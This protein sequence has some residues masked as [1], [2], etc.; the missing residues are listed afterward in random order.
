MKRGRLLL[1]AAL[2]AYGLSILRSTNTFT[3]LDNV[4]LPI[5][6]TG[7][8]VFAAFGEQITALGGTLFQFIVPLA[9]A[10]SFLIRGDRHAA[11]VM[12]WWIGQNCLYTGTYMADAV[13]QELP[14]VGGG[15]HDWS[16]LFGE[17]NVLAYSER[18]GHDARMAGGAI[19]L[20]ATIWGVLAAM[21]NVATDGER[22]TARPVRAR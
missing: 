4:N 10:I 8:L 3:L 22:E 12:L 7:H 1:T 20:A 11:S 13:V 5:H 6:E 2:A 15:E 16:F 21:R 17:W 14:L 19:M 9:F 18:I